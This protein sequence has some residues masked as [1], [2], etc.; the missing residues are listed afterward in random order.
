MNDPL[1]NHSKERALKH[2]MASRDR[3]KADFGTRF[4]MNDTLRV[5]SINNSTSLPSSMLRLIEAT[6]QTPYGH[7]MGRPEVLSLNMLLM[8][9]LNARKV[10]DIG[11]FTGLSA[12]AAAICIPDTGRV[13]AL[14]HSEN[15]IPVA[16]VE[17]KITLKIAPAAQSLKELLAFPGEE[18]TYD[19]AFVDA[20][21]ESYLEYFEL[22]LRLLRRGGIIAF[23]NVLWSGAVANPDPQDRATC[24]LVKLND[25]LAKDPRVLTSLVNIGDGLLLAHKL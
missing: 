15:Y 13:I 25:T 23:D 3:S 5:Y 9:T 20:D 4:D 21:K 10:L 12:L 7:I 16:G 24:T 8:R 2:I 11:V 22:T 17:H 19:F 14:D 6:K 18:G 1:Q